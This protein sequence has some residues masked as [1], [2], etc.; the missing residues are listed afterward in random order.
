MHIESKWQGLNTSPISLTVWELPRPWPLPG[1]VAEG[2]PDRQGTQ[3]K[4]SSMSKQ[5]PEAI[6]VAELTQ[7]ELENCWDEALYVP[8][9]DPDPFV[10]AQ[11]V[12]LAYHTFYATTVERT[13]YSREHAYLQAR[14][15]AR[16]LAALGAGIPLSAEELKENSF[17][18]FDALASWA[19]IEDAAVQVLRKIFATYALP[20]DGGKYSHVRVSKPRK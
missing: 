19:P 7:E 1:E 16:P 18:I 3:T 10:R 17:W 15:I 5:K 20:L 14:R 6:Y 12:V 11:K 13:R 2:Q 8:P 4:E 9:T